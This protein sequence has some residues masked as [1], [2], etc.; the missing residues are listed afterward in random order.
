MGEA[1]ISSAHS[2]CFP[3]E[4]KDHAWKKKKKKIMHAVFCDLSY[5]GM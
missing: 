4:G 2:E 3:Q 5:L 1:E